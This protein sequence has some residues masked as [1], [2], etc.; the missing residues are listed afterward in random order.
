[1]RLQHILVVDDSQSDRLLFESF[2]SKFRFCNQIDYATTLAEAKDLIEQHT[3]DRVFLDVNLP[4]G[5][6]LTL[7]SKVKVKNVHAKI[8]C[9]SVQT[10]TETL[11]V[12]QSVGVDWFLAKPIT[13]TML[14]AIAEKEEGF[15]F[16]LLTSKTS[17][18]CS[19]KDIAVA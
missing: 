4:D 9:T 10:N 12:A 14:L 6:G 2:F 17:A 1:M 11:E 15:F 5:N 13:W 19:I 3:Y 8:I 18:K 7:V 16:G